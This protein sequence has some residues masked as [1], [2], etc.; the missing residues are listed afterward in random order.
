MVV[1]VAMHE[2]GR[3]LT[4]D[5]SLD[6]LVYLLDKN[7]F[8][9]GA[10]IDYYD[11]DLPLP[12]ESDSVFADAPTPLGTAGGVKGAPLSSNPSLDV[13]GG[14]KGASISSNPSLDAAGGVKGAS[15]PTNPSLDAPGGGRDNSSPTIDGVPLR[16]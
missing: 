11:I 9:S 14:V 4:P 6:A 16:N 3:L 1:V 12:E 15:L 7:S 2:E 10:H 5:Q 13:A 8:E